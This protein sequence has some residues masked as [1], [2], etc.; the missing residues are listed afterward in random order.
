MKPSPPKMKPAA[1]CCSTSSNT[2]PVRQDRHSRIEFDQTCS[3][4][5]LP[6]PQWPLLFL[7]FRAMVIPGPPIGSPSGRSKIRILSA[8]LN[9][10]GT[11]QTAPSGSKHS[12]RQCAILGQ[13]RFSSHIAWAVCSSLTG[14][15]P[16]A[17]P[18]RELSSLRRPIRW[19][20]R[21]RPPSK[22]S[23]PCRCGGF[24][25][26]RSWSRAA[27]IRMRLPRSLHNARLLGVR[28]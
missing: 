14:R 4:P 3:S 22:V 23:R 13:K 25:S 27:T 20:P 11:S 17:T 10:T 18:S 7:F 5:L 2:T 12:K 24:P 21:S 6:N 9:A 28:T 19:P 1:L 8:S 15:A 16:V 26:R